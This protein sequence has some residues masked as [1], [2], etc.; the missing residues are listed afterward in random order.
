MKIIFLIITGSDDNNIIYSSRA[1]QYKVLCD[2]YRLYYE[3]MKNTYD[4]EY[5]F[6]EYNENISDEVEEHGNFIYVKGKEKF[7]N[8]HEKTIKS[9]NYINKTYKYDYIVRTNA[10]SLWNIPN[11]YRMALTFPTTKCLTG[12]LMFNHFISGTGIIMSY[13]VG[14]TLGE[15]PLIKN[16]PDDVLITDQLKQFYEIHPIDEKSMYYL[17]SNDQNTIPDNKDNILYFRI[18]NSDLQCDIKAIEVLLYDIYGISIK[19]T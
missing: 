2:Y 4:L 18:K 12:V 19:T 17:I 11:L 7:E 6:N 1:A 9:I 5:F 10:S 16:I 13:D 14:K 8:I 15:Q 3:K